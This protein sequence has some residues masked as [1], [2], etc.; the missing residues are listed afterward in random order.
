MSRCIDLAKNGLGT[1]YPNPSVGALLVCDQKIIGEG[2]T[3]PYGGP[4][5]EVNAI[6]SVQDI[7]LLSQSILYVTLE[8][9]SHHGKTPPCS[10]LI[11]EKRIKKVV[12]GCKD[13]NALVAGQGIERLKEAGCEVVLSVLELECKEHHK[14]FLT[15]HSQKRPYII[16][17]WAETADGFIAPLDKS[18]NKLEP[19]WIT[20]TASRQLVHKWR[21]EEQAIL[22]G[23][24]TVLLD[25]PTLTTRDWKGTSPIRVVIDKNLRISKE[26]S[27]M[28][29]SVKTIVITE[30]T[31]PQEENI[32]FEKV[33]F[34]KNIP[35]QIMDVLHR[36]HILSV[37]I[38]GGAKTIQS[39]ID[40]NLWDNAR[41]FKSDSLFSEGIT[42][43]KISATISSEENIKGDHLFVYRND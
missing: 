36:H 14:R 5:A 9:C 39:F 43:P 24:Q 38:E 30:K 33:D 27:V 34:S 4:H 35:T 6:R 1:T 19:V 40:A 15:Y 11:I 20:N 17:K 37:I 26:A 16:L 7:S 21:A 8:P 29:G 23:T 3:S 32:A 12:I 42:A 31:I 18:R 13:T 25:N 10:D 2:Y 41:V 28:D 22:V